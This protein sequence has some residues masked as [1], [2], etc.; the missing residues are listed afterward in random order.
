MSTKITF[1]QLSFL[2]GSVFNPNTPVS[3]KDLFSGRAQQVDRVLEVISQKGQ[4]VIIFGERGVGKTSLANVLSSFVPTQESLLSTR[5]NCDRSDNFSSVWRKLFDGLAL[6]RDKETVSFKPTITK[7]SVHTSEFFPNAN[8][9]PNDVKNALLT[10][11][12]NFLP[13]LIIDEFDRLDEPERRTFSDLIKSLSDYSL[14][15]TIILIGV[16]NS[17]GDIINEHQSVSRALVQ[18]QMPRMIQDEIKSIIL[19]SLTKLNMQ[20]DDDSLEQIVLLSKGLPHYTHLIG[21]HSTRDALAN[22]SYTIHGDNIGVAIRKAVNDAQYSIKTAYHSAISSAKKSNLFAEVLLACALAQTNEMDEF[23]AQDIGA[24]L[25][26]VT[27]KEY[28]I[29]A[30]VTHLTE[31][32]EEKRGHILIKTGQKRRYRYKFSDPLMQPF[33][34]MQGILSGKIN[35]DSQ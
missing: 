32:S 8:I 1:E 14:S 12:T 5:I 4:H 2:A 13:V 16:G 9:T 24:P 28:K 19:N 22:Y 35:M 25:K 18:V 10:I 15:A 33:I 11:S 17:V 20:I 31:F 30:Y 3:E 27:Q 34:I 21:L 23:A 26:I 6:V 29:A 7:E